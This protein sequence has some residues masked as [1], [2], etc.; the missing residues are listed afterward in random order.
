MELLKFFT[1]KNIMRHYKFYEILF[2]N[3]KT[4]NAIKKCYSFFILLLY[5]VNN[6]IMNPV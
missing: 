1:K 4:S 6:L 2:L 5:V 3:Q